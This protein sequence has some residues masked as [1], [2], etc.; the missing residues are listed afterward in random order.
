MDETCHI[1]DG[2]WG[3]F[4]T[5]FQMDETF[6]TWGVVVSALDMVFQSDGVFHTWDGASLLDMV[7]PLDDTVRI[8]CVGQWELSQH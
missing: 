3:E 5:V 1:W 7:Y 2:A 4:R 6:H 8:D